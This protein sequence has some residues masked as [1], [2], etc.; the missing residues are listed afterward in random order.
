MASLQSRRRGTLRF[1]AEQTALDEWLALRGR[2]RDIG[3]C[4][5]RRSGARPQLVKGYGDTHARGQAK[6]ARLVALLPRLHGQ[7]NAAAQM[8]ALIKAA[9]A[10]EDGKALE[11]AILSTWPD[12]S[13]HSRESLSGHSRASG[14][15]VASP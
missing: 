1:A 13:A 14:N 8:A 5:G 15:P 3:L 4:A 12:L 7:A 11:Q 9:L 10:D 6:Y 2:D